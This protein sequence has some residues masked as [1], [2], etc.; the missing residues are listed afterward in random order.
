VAEEKKA[1]RI[2]LINIRHPFNEAPDLT[3]LVKAVLG[4]EEKD[5]LQVR[6]LRRSIDS[7]QERIDCVYTLLVELAVSAGAAEE[8]LKRGDVESY[9]E[10]QETVIKAIT[11][12]KT[13]P[14]II[15]CGPAGLFTA[16]TLVERGLR[17][18]LIER[19]AR[20]AQRV[21][22]VDAFWKNGMLDEESNVLFGEGGAGTF[23]DGKLTTRIKSPL[24]EKVLREL[25]RFGA[26]EE[27]LYVSKPYLGTDRIRLIISRVVEYL[28]QSSTEFIFNARVCDM[29]VKDGRVFGVKAGERFIETETVFLAT[30]HSGRDI[31]HM[32]ENCGV[33]L[34]AKGFAMGL[35]I[36]HPQEFI[37]QQQW[38]KWAGTPG[39]DAADYFLSYKDSRS[40][41]GVYSFCMCPGGYVI[42]CSSRQGELVSNGMSPYRRDSAWANA[43]MVVTVGTDDFSSQQPLAGIAL[44]RQLEEKAFLAGGGTFMLPAQSARDFMMGAGVAGHLPASSCLPGAA[45]ADLGELI[46]EFLKSPLQRALHHFDMKMPGF[47]DNGIL[48]GVESRTSSPVRITRDPRT[49]HAA[50]V[51]GLIPIGEGSGYAGGIMSCAVDGIRA[52]LAFDAA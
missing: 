39:L 28:E 47:I 5:L 2:R 26:P 44:Q 10:P 33:E 50:G 4:V 35:R 41:R 6:I 17:P 22:D 42:A 19:G 18:I 48:F 40:N 23:S 25:V 24:K 49:F 37:N 7:R 3:V 14:V 9:Q 13:I 34:E 21:R 32:L 16:L 46:P 30:G 36:E 20:M 15:G 8:I 31:Y 45:P 38:G 43:A 52:A 11:G 1:I 27:I 29:K 51:K 12:L